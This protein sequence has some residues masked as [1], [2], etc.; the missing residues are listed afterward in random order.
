YELSLVPS[1]RRQVGVEGEEIERNAAVGC[2]PQHFSNLVGEHGAAI[3]GESHHL[4]LALVDGES[5]PGGEGRVEHPERMREA[6][7][8][9]RSQLGASVLVYR[10]VTQGKRGPLTD[11]V[12]GEDGRG[13]GRRGEEGGR[14][15]RLVMLGEEHLA[16]R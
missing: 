8:S 2:A 5:K 15:V 3:R 6:D 11:A 4:V 1:A 16:R 10:A 7:L 13:A 12:G 14:R 9:R